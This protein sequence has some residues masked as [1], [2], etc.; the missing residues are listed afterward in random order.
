M[1]VTLSAASSMPSG[2]MP[3]GQLERGLALAD[4]QKAK[5][6]IEV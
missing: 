5:T 6:A 2:H 1:Q 4:L 3:S